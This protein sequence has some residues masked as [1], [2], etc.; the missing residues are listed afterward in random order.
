M[1][2]T[3]EKSTKERVLE[4]REK[5]QLVFEEIGKPSAYFYPKIAYRPTDKDELY[6]SFFPSELNKGDDIYTEF[7]N[8]DYNPEDSNRTLWV[9]KYNP[10][11][12][13]EY[14]PTQV[15]DLSTARYLVPVSELSK[16]NL[17][18]KEQEADPFKSLVDFTD[19]CAL[20]QMTVRDFATIMLGRPLSHKTWLNNL[21]TGNR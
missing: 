15:N 13:E 14:E 16:V 11:W 17:P 3:Q 21:I 10:H 19:D 7:I 12:K 1:I 18:K 9:L 5:H 6:V 20:S 4:L 8:R 2:K